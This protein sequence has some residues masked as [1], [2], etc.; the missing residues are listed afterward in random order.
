MTFV[1]SLLAVT[2]LV[3]QLGLALEPRRRQPP[4]PA[5]PTRTSPVR[6]AA[7]IG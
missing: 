4:Q 3:V 1:I 5:E 6:V 2:L 7:D